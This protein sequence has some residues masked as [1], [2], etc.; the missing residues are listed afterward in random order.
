M[1]P[2]LVL[3]SIILP[4]FFAFVFYID[5]SS[6]FSRFWR[7]LGGVWGG[8]KALKIEIWGVLGGMLFETLFLVIFSSIFVKIDGEKH[9]DF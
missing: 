1:H 6:I 3:K 2:K 8:Q 4:H 9:Q 7:G 5:L